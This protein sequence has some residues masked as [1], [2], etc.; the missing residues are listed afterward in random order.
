MHADTRKPSQPKGTYR[1]KNWR[2]YN[3][4][5]IRRGDVRVWIDESLLRSRGALIPGRRGRPQ[6]YTDPMIQMLLGLKSVFHLPLR[7]LQGFGQSICELVMP[8]VNVPNYTTLSRRAQTL[9]VALPVLRDP[10]EA[11]H[12]LVDSTGLKLFG[13][14]EWK[15]RKHGWSKRR[16]WRKLHLGMDAKTGQACAVLLTHRDVD[17][18]SVLPALLDQVPSHTPIEAV[19]GDGAYDTKAAWAVIAERAAQAV[20]P[21]V[22]GGRALARQVAWCATAQ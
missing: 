16:S 21:P 7:A 15:V 13:E 3:A 1:V 22:E 12:M 20:I 17:D 14:G 4:G 10:A 5:L 18:A 6:Q 19:A 9:E 2:E 8:E 11:I